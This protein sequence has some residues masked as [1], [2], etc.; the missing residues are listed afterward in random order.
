MQR[1]LANRICLLTVFKFVLT[2]LA[3][4]SVWHCAAIAVRA[5]ERSHPPMRPLPVATQRAM[6]E[7]PAYFVDA[8][9]GDDSNEG[10]QQKPWRT[11]AR[12]VKGLRPGNTL[13]LRAGI[14]FESVVIDAIGTAEKPITIRVFPGELAILDAGLREF[15]EAPAS[16]WEPVP[17]GAKD[18][19]Q[20]TRTYRSG[21]GFGNFADSMIPFHRYMNLT[22]LR[23]LNELYHVGL[24]DRQDD[25][26]GIYCGPGT[27]RDPETGRIHIR[28]SHTLLAGL[29]KDAYRGETD[30]R[31]LPLVISG[32][33]YALRIEGARHLRIQDLVV[34]GA[35][36]SAVL[37]TRDQEDIDHDAEDIELDGVTLYGSGAALRISHTKRLRIVNSNLRGHSA[38]WHSRFT[39]KNRAGS[40]YLIFAEGRD[41]EIAHCELTD[42][43]DCI[44]FHG[45]DGLKFHHNLV[46]N[47]NDD[48]IEPGPKKA[49]GTT[50]VYQ[51]LIT[52]TLNPFTAHGNKPIPIDAEPGSGMYVFRNVVD[53]RQ[54]TYKG[55][56]TEPDPSGKFLNEP[57]QLVCHD[58]GSP[59]HAIYYV[60]HNT[61]LL[62]QKAFRDYYG[63][64]WGSQSRLTTRRV[65]NN[66]FVQDEG[67][68]G[69]NFGGL[70]ADDDFRADANL[71]WGFK[72]G[73]TQTADYFAKFRKSPLF[74]AS[75][76]Q[77]PPGWGAND[78]LADPQ[79]TSLSVN[80]F[81]LSS[82]SPAVDAG[83]DIP[84]EWPDTL[85]DLDKGRPDLGAFPIGAEKL[86]VGR[87]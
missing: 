87:Q 68:P 44:T 73:P 75:Q 82:G 20:S 63:F 77:Y 18:E 22:D 86:R 58:H 42:H 4:V 28:L 41:F 37:I 64:S 83:V 61:F 71:L 52:R 38:P 13:L 67:L 15:Q 36:R 5:S 27:R 57:T 19:F 81:R 78:R 65:F 6:P 45:L 31:K 39:V 10:S 69:L 33:E 49:R 1:N 26:V 80:D 60:Y 21:G 12:A 23:S 9:R 70:K 79:F 35:E 8:S 34:R 56:P 3:V 85:R 74:E 48:G 25:P 72:D 14:Y 17:N 54:G 30:P 16:A 47:F 66:I 76:K 62:H 59:V 43:H 2:A 55:P 24:S 51:N 11:L 46:D 32:H 40:G 7:G 29:G 84:T 50:L 53:L